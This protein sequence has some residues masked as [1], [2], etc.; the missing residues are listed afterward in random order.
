MPVTFRKGS[1]PQG[2]APLRET[3]HIWITHQCYSNSI[4]YPSAPVL[5]A[6]LCATGWS[7][8]GSRF[9]V[10][11]GM[12]PGTFPLRAAAWPSQRPMYSLTHHSS[13]AALPSSAHA[14]KEAHLRRVV[15]L[16]KEPGTHTHTPTPRGGI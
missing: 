2:S 8:P 3:Y 7:S 13:P 5:L 4:S 15:V 6:F 16:P 10:V 14:D 12:F 9:S 11:L 1:E